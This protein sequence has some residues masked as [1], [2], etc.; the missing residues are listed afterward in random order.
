MKSAWF[1]V[2]NFTH[3]SIL[4]FDESVADSVRT[5]RRASSNIDSFV[6]L[7]CRSWCASN[8]KVC[9]FE[10]NQFYFFCIVS[11]GLLF[12]W[13]DALRQW[14]VHSLISRS[15]PML[16]L[17]S[18]QLLADWYLCVVLCSDETLLTFLFLVLVGSSWITCKVSCSQRLFDHSHSHEIS[19]HNCT[20]FHKQV[21]WIVRFFFF[22]FLNLFLFS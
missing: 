19:P 2:F 9:L 22:V 1:W 11:F 5:E 7:W 12:D 21:F 18:L 10:G 20:R 16:D 13:I 3:T 17:H 15:S 6:W 8:D 14:T 4:G